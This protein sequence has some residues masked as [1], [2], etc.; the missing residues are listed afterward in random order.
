MLYDLLTVCSRRQWL[1][2]SW[3]AQYSEWLIKRWYNAVIM[4]VLILISQKRAQTK[5]FSTPRNHRYHIAVKSISWDFR[6]NVINM[7]YSF[8]VYEYIPMDMVNESLTTDINLIQLYLHSSTWVR[9]RLTIPY[10]MYA[11]MHIWWCSLDRG[12]V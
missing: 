9:R 3:F 1:L 7:T 12:F 4:I 6:G 10:I 11:Q 2:D 5:W 8:G